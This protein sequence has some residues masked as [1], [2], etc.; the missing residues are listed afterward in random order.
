MRGATSLVSAG[1]KLPSRMEKTQI[2]FGWKTG[3]HVKDYISKHPEATREGLLNLYIN[4]LE[5]DGSFGRFILTVL[6]NSTPDD[7]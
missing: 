2:E 4:R 7:Q 3:P 5:T 6:K 1:L